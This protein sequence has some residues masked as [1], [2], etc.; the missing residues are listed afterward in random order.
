LRRLSDGTILDGEVVVLRDGKSDFG[1]LQ[2][3]EQARSALKIRTKSSA[4][5][6]TFIAFDILYDH[7]LSVMNR[8]L[9]ERKALL[10]KLVRKADLPALVTAQGITGAGR[11]YF[12]RAVDEG[13]EGLIAKRIDSLYLPGKR[14]NAWIKIKRRQELYCVVI[15]F[16][17]S[18]KNDFRSL[19]VAS[20]RDGQLGCV[21]KVGT[22]FNDA[23]RKRLNNWLW[24]H[25]QPRP[26]I[27][28]KHKGHWVEPK[29]V[30]RLLA[31][32]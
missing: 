11:E 6:A 30:C 7:G 12:R 14:T 26:V 4:N 3:R 10:E 28:C 32:S 19:I 15:G 31:W 21:G 22:G 27:A 29:T 23:M 20:E 9:L 16:E 8:P 2:S 5:P 13:L 1:L 25:L 24:S 18:G 17:P